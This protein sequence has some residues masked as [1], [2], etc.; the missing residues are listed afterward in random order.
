MNELKNIKDPA[1]LQWATF[2]TGSIAAR[3]VGG[4]GTT[5]GSV[6]VSDIKNNFLNHKQMLDDSLTKEQ[7]ELMAKR[8]DVLMGADIPG[9]EG[10]VATADALTPDARAND[11]KYST[12]VQDALNQRAGMVELAN[13]A[14]VAGKIDLDDRNSIVER[15]NDESIKIRSGADSFLGSVV[16]A[17][18][19]AIANIPLAIVV[20]HVINPSMLGNADRSSSALQKVFDPDNKDEILHAVTLRGE[21]D[22]VPSSAT[23]TTPDD[24][25]YLGAAVVLLGVTKGKPINLPSWK[26]IAIDIEHIASGHMA[27]GSRTVL[28]VSK[29]LF[30]EYM[31]AEQV[32]SAVRT[33]YR[34]GEKIKTQ[35]DNV[36]IRG[37]SDGLTIEMW[38]NK[39]T[40]TIETAYP[41]Y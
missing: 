13:S 24:N 15:M 27:D 10:G 37:E 33:A 20:D 41:K 21:T 4:D 30:P 12:E 5:G 3:L 11:E 36:L 34:F 1:L 40:K 2:I 28:G 7:R 8:Q 31:N 16:T 32:E 26:N 9:E 6:T 25:G 35:G 29:D 19:L 38:V 14:Y 17:I 18:P 39:V 23:L 22:Y